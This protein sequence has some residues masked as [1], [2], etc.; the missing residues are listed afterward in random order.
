MP[1]RVQIQIEATDAASGVLRAITSQFGSLGAAASDLSD[2][3]SKKSNA[4]KLYNQ[5]LHDTSISVK[6]VEAAEMAAAAATARFA[7]TAVLMLI[8]GLKD[9][10]KASQAYAGSVRDLAIASGTGADE[11]SRLLQV[12]DDYQITAEDL[13]TASRKMKD[14]GLVPTVETLAQLSAE[15]I[16]IND[17]AERLAFAQDN[18]GRSS[19]KF[20]NVLSQG[21]DVIRANGEAVSEML[22]LTDEQIA[23][24]EEQRLALD[25]LADSWEGVKVQTG[26]AVGEIVLAIN[27]M[28]VGIDLANKYAAAHG[29]VITNQRQAMEI[30]ELA[31]NEQRSLNAAVER[32]EAMMRAY[33]IALDETSIITEEVSL[34][35]SKLIGDIQG[36]QA[37]SDKYGETISQLVVEEDELKKARSAAAEQLAKTPLWG[38]GNE[39]KAQ[40]LQNEIA[41]I[42]SK[43]D[44]NAAKVKANADAYQDW[45]AQTVYAFATAR[46]GA[47]GSISA[48]EGEVLIDAG[49]ALGLFDEKTAEAMTN[50]NK[51]FDNLDASNAQDVITTLQEQLAALTGQP[52]NITITANASGS[53]TATNENSGNAEMKQV[54]GTVYAGNP[55]IVGERGA[56]PF[57]PSV[58]GR[59][60]GHAESLHALSMGGGG[61]VN[62]FYGN[63]TLQIGEG[64]ASGLMGLR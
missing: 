40:D 17:P 52:Y 1:A 26:M 34:D 3:F 18:L 50:V 29:V 9:A 46:A 4:T 57:F 8:T 16:R 51:A 41:S 22:I 25:A 11:A 13:T 55:Y 37:A 33:G 31:R 58:N 30:T 42:D 61:G 15:F 14:N 60:L 44:E 59:V 49:V 7:E 28:D 12:L 35:Y 27:E 54:G 23:K 47:D 43:L 19:A 48:I 6:E 45:A 2:V 53:G 62:N 56:E 20:L 63:V 39:K 10:F 21:P 32:G 24:S 5:A 38:K 36:A 64:E